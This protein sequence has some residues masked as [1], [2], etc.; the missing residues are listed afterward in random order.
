MLTF[1]EQ[2]ISFFNQNPLIALFTGGYLL[3]T[4]GDKRE[5]ELYFKRTWQILIAPI[6]LDEYTKAP[7]SLQSFE[8]WLENFFLTTYVQKA[9]RGLT[10]YVSGTFK[11]TW[12]KT[13]GWLFLDIMIVAFLIADLI[14]IREI[15][16]LLGFPIN[17]SSLGA[18]SFLERFDYGFA[19]TAGTFFS[20]IASGFVLFETSTKPGKESEFSNYSSEF[21]DTLRGAIKY[22]AIITIISS[23]LVILF[24]GLRA[25]AVATTLPNNIANNINGLAQFGGNVLVRFNAFIVTL[26][27]STES[28][29]GLQSIFI[30]LILLS[31][32]L[33]ALVY[34]VTETITKL[35]RVVFDIIYRLFLWIIWTLSFWIAKPIDKLISPVEFIWNK[36]FGK[37][38]KDEN[39]EEEEAEDEKTSKKK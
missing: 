8:Q 9:L 12:K 15:A 22:S 35:L 31:I 11:T 28:I 33:L 14:T 23:L 38:N 21:Y 36:M 10:N 7:G 5:R 13:V 26:I 30:I 16:S 25:F 37:K 1:L 39:K 24:F 6:Q 32:I 34:L 3:I 2:L 18:L 20:I 27:I 29:N 4:F 19:I 17:F